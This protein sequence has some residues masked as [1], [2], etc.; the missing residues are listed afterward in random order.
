MGSRTWSVH[1]LVIF[2]CYSRSTD[3][4][5]LEASSLSGDNVEA[6]FLLA[7]RAILLAIESGMLDPEKAGSGDRK[8]VV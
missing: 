5:F 2:P 3:L 6:P 7:A 8:S 1:S 4:H